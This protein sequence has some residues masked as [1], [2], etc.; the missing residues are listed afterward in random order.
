MD[1]VEIRLECLRV[2][3]EY[4]TQRD[5]VNPA[6]LAE[7]YYEWVVRGSEETRPADNRKD[8]SQSRLKR[9]G[10]SVHRVALCKAK[11]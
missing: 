5:V 7:S 10:M 6:K 11:T 8:D 4:G 3:L 2:A 1:D 9:L